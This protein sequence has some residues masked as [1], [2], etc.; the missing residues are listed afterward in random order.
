MERRIVLLDACQPI[1]FGS[2]DRLD[3]LLNLE[4][5][6]V[7]IGARAASEVVCDPARTL[8]RSAIED[9]SLP[10]ASVDPEQL[11]ELSALARYDS[12]LAF[13]GRGEAEV[14]AIAEARGHI[15]GTDDEAVLRTAVRVPG[16]TG[17]VTSLDL[18]VWAIREERITLRQSEGLIDRLDIGLRIRDRLNRLGRKLPELV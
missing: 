16:I 2:V 14:L 10:V 7:A 6:A 15:V 5:H 12:M 13:Q 1:T 3:L 8:T 11:D 18:I 17:I 4:R 9:G